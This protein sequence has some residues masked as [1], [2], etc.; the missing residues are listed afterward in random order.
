MRLLQFSVFHLN[1]AVVPFGLG[2]VGWLEVLKAGSPSNRPPAKG[3]LA[4]MGAEGRATSAIE[5]PRA[6]PPGF[7]VARKRLIADKRRENF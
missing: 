2:F 4:A 3:S 1:G 6:P 7:S 5:F